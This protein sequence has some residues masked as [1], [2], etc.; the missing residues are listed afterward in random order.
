M[1]WLSWATASQSLNC[2]YVAQQASLGRGPTRDLPNGYTLH[3]V[4]RMHRFDIPQHWLSSN[5]LAGVDYR[6]LP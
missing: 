5:G 1:R 2:R 6:L 3:P 4:L